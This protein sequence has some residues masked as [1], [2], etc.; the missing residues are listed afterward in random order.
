MQNRPPDKRRTVIWLSILTVS[1]CIAFT[2]YKGSPPGANTT[3]SEAV[4]I[5]LQKEALNDSGQ[6]SFPFSQEGVIEY[7]ESFYDIMKSFGVSDSDVLMISTASRKV[8]NLRKLRAGRPYRI[9]LDAPGELKRFKY[10]INNQRVLVLERESD[11]WTSRIDP[12]EYQIREHVV[13]GTIEDSLYVSLMEICASTVLASELSDI[14]AWD[15]DFFLDLRP[16]DTFGILYEERW[17]EDRLM[18]IGR[19]L[20]AQFINKGITFSAVYF[21]SG[22]DRGDYF[23]EEGRSLQKQFLKS[24]LRFK[25]ISSYFSRNRLHPILKIRRPHLGIDYAAPRGTPVR[26]AA[27]GRVIFKGRKGGMGKMIKVRHNGVYTTAYGHLS[28]YKKGLKKGTWVTQGQVI[29]YVGSTGLSTGPH[30]HYSFY[31]NGRLINPV[32]ANNPRAKSIDPEDL[33]EYKGI[34]EELLER[35]RPHRYEKITVAV[36]RSTH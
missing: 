30:L 14:F 31:R 19:I 27:D 17:K 24:P 8:Y 1:G 18:G 28:G 29:G 12:I 32:R 4:P 7:G 3:S 26:A 25:Y 13:R 34:S 9:E 6:L 10:T 5:I 11:G 21:Q 22:N 36:R 15:I 23:D 16:G 35:V 20:A 2:L 33:S